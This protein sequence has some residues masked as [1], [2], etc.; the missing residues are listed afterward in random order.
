MSRDTRR[1]H[2]EL[3]RFFGLVWFKWLGWFKSFIWFVSFIWFIR[4]IG[5]V[6]KPLFFTSAGFGDGE[7][8]SSRPPKG[9]R[10]AFPSRSAEPFV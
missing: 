4:F 3:G 8:F 6:E 7:F 9:K 1:Q 10:L 2:P 5:F